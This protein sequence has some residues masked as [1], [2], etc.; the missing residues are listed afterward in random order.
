MLKAYDV[1]EKEDVYSFSESDGYL[2]YLCSRGRLFCPYCEHMNECGGV[3]YVKEHLRDGNKVV[4]HF[5]RN[6]TC[7]YM[8]T[9]PKAT[10]GESSEHRNFKVKIGS[11]LKDKGY[12]VDYEV[13]MDNHIVDV[14]AVKDNQRIAIECQLSSIPMDNILDRNRAYKLAGYKCL[15]VV[16]FSNS[17]DVG[18]RVKL[19][20]VHKSISKVIMPCVLSYFDDGVDVRKSIWGLT[21]ESSKGK[22]GWTEVVNAHDMLRR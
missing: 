6:S 18:T 11:F 13:R 15:W 8:G 17:P 2:K 22:H 12:N 9:L 19:E 1:N 16:K 14:T 20:S 10:E 3:S 21:L 4:S 5:R 7:K